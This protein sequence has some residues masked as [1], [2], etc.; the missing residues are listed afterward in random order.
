MS[1]VLRNLPVNQ[2]AAWYRRLADH[3]GRRRIGEEEPLSAKFLRHWLDNRDSTSTFRLDAPNYLR[4]S[5]FVFEVLQYHRCVFLTEERARITGRHSIWAGVLPRLRGTGGFTRW[6]IDKSLEMNYE[7]LVEISLW[8]QFHGTD[9]EKDLLA[10]LRGFQL[11]SR[12]VVVGIPVPRS[13]RKLITF[14]LWVCRVRDRYDFDYNEHFTVPNP[15][16]G[17]T[18]PNAVQPGDQSIKV[19]HRNA[20]RLEQ[21]NLAAPYD[22]EMNEWAVDDIRIIR[23]AQVG[24]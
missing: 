16:F 20:Q 21:A 17:S 9:G 12:V 22:I 8:I 13:S 24:P 4:Q 19:Y 14:I 18:Q 23:N 15:D 5:S 2:V 3:T 1:D 7:S 10:A 6:T 11:R